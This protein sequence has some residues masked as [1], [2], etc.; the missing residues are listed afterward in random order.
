MSL[1]VLIIP[2][3]FKGTLTAGAAAEAIARG[4]RAARSDG[5]L[6]LLPMTDGGDGFG[7]V[8]SQL[9][10]ALPQ[11]ARTLNA[12][13]RPCRGK[14]WWQPKTKTALIESAAVIGLAMLPARKFH[15]FQLDTFGLGQLLKIIARRGA[16]R[17]L[18]GIGGSATNDGGFGLGRALGWQFL[19]RT[20]TALEHWT[21]LCQLDSLLPPEK[22]CKFRELVVATDVQNPLVGPRGATRIYGPQKGLLARQIPSAER[23]LQRL[24][25][26]A[27][28]QFGREIASL[29]G[30]GAAGGLGFGLVTFA[31]A[32]LSSGFELFSRQAGLERRLR[33]AD[34]V[35]TGEG[36]LD[37]SSMMGKGVGQIVRRCCESNIPCI[38]LAG[39][40]DLRPKARRM[41]A[42]IHSLT[43]MAGFGQATSK[44][45]F[46]LERLACDTA[47]RWML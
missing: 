23:C 14:W 20:G 4:W 6:D 9:L 1:N 39:K 47:K 37:N 24:A 33:R 30:A 41:F 46:W 22:L 15:P 28:R 26:V 29:S 27:C 31:G 7:E 18:V 2:D 11:S 3:K 35:I 19:D 44:P 38:G 25:D 36:A 12:G 5:T 43:E 34:L 40:V 17:F 16:C 13:H 45:G 10:S 42:Q 8:M 21:D 32:R